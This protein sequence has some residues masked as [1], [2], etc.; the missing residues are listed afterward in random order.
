MLVGDRF[1]E[2][3]KMSALSITL[4]SLLPDLIAGRYVE[5]NGLIV[6]GADS[7]DELMDH[8]LISTPDEEEHGV[9]Y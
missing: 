4:K 6:F 3:N 8:L 7:F 9:K 2:E 1:R 5:L